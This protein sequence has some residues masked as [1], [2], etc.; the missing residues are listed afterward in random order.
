M[1]KENCKRS[2]VC[3]APL[4]PLDKESLKN[5]IWY[6]NEEICKLRKFSNEKFIKN[7]KK[8]IKKI[9]SDNTYFTYNMLNQNIKISDDIQGL[10]PDKI[11]A[12]IVEKFEKEKLKAVNNWIK[13]YRIKDNGIG[14]ERKKENFE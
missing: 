13:S 3:N 14:K 11:S 4:C 9:K 10:D 8:I 1:R 5:G 2:N 6:P 12:N 7:Q